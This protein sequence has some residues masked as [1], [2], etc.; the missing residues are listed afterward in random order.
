MLKCGVREGVFFA[1]LYKG[2]TTPSCQASIVD[3]SANLAVNMTRFSLIFVDIEVKIQRLLQIDSFFF[4]DGQNKSSKN[5]LFPSVRKI[6]LEP[7]LLC[8]L[9]ALI[10]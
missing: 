1:E 3:H 6:L 7:D 4:Y 2:S 8:L 5:S 9:L 10:D